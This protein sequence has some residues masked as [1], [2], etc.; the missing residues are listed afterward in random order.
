MWWSERG[1][2]GIETAIILIAFVV[3]AA[4][5]AYTALSAG[6]FATQ[7]SQE[8]IYSGLKSVQ[9]TLELKGSVTATANNTG[10][11]G[12]I[13][14]ISFIVANVLGGEPLDF[15]APD[16][17]ASN[18]GTA[19][20]TSTNKV[21]I[22]Y[23]DQYQKVSNLFWTFTP[24]GNDNGNQM[25]EQN[26][27]FEITV[28]STTPGQDGGNLI[29]ALDPDLGI[30]TTFTLEMLTPAGAVLIIPRTIPG[31]VDQVINLH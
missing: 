2:T 19:A 27:R 1:I 15:T 6:L 23:I 10:N 3:V 25:L 8:S 14:Q 20:S 11:N 31:S 29:D 18:N 4:V 22:N 26:E 16:E 21:V 9:S 5:F 30:N 13:K 28:G 17:D 7:E 12:H 24:L